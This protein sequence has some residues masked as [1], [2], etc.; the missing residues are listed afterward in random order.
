M[1][2]ISEQGPM[3]HKLDD[4]W[5]FYETV[6]AYYRKLPTFRWL[7]ES[8]IHP[9]NSTSYSLSKIQKA[10]T[11]GYGELPFVGCGGPKYNETEAGRGSDD[12]GGTVLNEIWYY[13]HVNGA[14]QRVDGVKTAV[15]ESYQTTCAKAKNA[16]WYY[17]RTEGS[18]KG[19]GGCS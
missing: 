10:L 15:P 16:V 13:F 18:E 12:N 2:F 1:R 4:L 7:A 14:S 19:S 5:D 9:S 17:E 11:H 6:I 8:H 3:M